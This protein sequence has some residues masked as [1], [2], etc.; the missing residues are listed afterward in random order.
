M[1]AFHGLEDLQQEQAAHQKGP[2]E[3][4][5]SHSPRPGLAT[6]QEPD[7]ERGVAEILHDDI[8]RNEDNPKVHTY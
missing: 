6:P 4:G 7:L 8:R 2:D 1:K 5:D 3:Y